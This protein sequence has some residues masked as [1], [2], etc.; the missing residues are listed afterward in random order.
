MSLYKLGIHLDT[1]MLPNGTWQLSLANQF[2]V[3]FRV[4]SSGNSSLIVNHGGLTVIGPLVGV[5]TFDIEV[6]WNGNLVSTGPTTP[7]TMILTSPLT[8]TVNS[9]TYSTSSLGSTSLALNI[10]GGETMFS[11]GGKQSI[12]GTVSFSAAITEFS[13]DGIPLT[14]WTAQGVYA[15]VTISG[16]YLMY[17]GSVGSGPYTGLTT[18]RFTAYN[19][20][21]LT[22]IYID[23]TGTFSGDGMSASYS[24]A[25]K[26]SSFG[27]ASL[28]LPGPYIFL[29]YPIVPPGISFCN[30]AYADGSYHVVGHWYT[31]SAVE[32]LAYWRGDAGHPRPGYGWDLTGQHVTTTP[33]D[34]NPCLAIDRGHRLHLVFDRQTSAGPPRVAPAYEMHSD[35]DGQ[36]WSVP[37][38]M[39]IAN[40]QYPRIRVGADGSIMRAAYVD[41]GTGHSTGTIKGQYQAPGD[42]APSTAFTFNKWNGS[43]M[44]P[45]TAQAGCFD[46]DLERDSS[47]QWIMTVLE[48][49]NTQPTEW[50]SADDGQ[51]WTATGS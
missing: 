38:A 1:P 21:V 35:D 49:G 8:I 11:F 43:A 42:P 39:T 28:Q 25:Y 4:D 5:T 14:G 48:T 50:T 10:I 37:T 46:I 32:G 34:D 27:F 15:N 26:F 45:I 12:S 31:G 20:P 18:A 7:G 3:N 30:V 40:A 19:W 2:Q 9:S 17:F 22:T 44:V 23:G 6:S 51:S 24:A 47:G 36:T 29:G 13:Q 33:A 16:E 41:D